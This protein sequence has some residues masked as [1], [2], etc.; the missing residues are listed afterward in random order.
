[1]K[2]KPAKPGAKVRAAFKKLEIAFQDILSIDTASMTEALEFGDEAW[3]LRVAVIQEV[4]RILEV[5][6]GIEGRRPLFNPAD[7][8]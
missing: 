2:P 4:E 5:L 6:E 3:M 8:I 7:E 1:V